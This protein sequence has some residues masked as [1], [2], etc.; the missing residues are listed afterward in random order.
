[1]PLC[2]YCGQE[3]GWFHDA[4]KSCRQKASQAKP[5]I[6]TIR[7]IV[8]NAVAHGLKYDE[9]K[10]AADGIADQFHVSRE[11]VLEAINEGWSKEQRHEA[12]TQPVSK[13]EGLAARAGR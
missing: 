7:L 2:R 4:H 5:A 11:Q 13:E 6:E 3:A 1:M 10:S 8:S 9:V 12:E